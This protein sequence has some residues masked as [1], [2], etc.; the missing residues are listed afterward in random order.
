[1]DTTTATDR[2]LTEAELAQRYGL[3]T[4]TLQGWRKNG[5]GP[6]WIVIGKNTIR[7][8]MEDVL[9]HEQTRTNN[10]PQGEGK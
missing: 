2:L 3:T 7:Y 8:R 1:M 5:I 9:A 4:R 10:Q 6:A